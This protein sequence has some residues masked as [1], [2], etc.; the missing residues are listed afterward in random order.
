[1]HARDLGK[2]LWYARIALAIIGLLSSVYL[3]YSAAFDVQVACPTAGVI[4]CGAVLNS[5]YAKTFGIPNGYLGVLFFAAVLA[6][7]YL[8]RAEPLAVLNAIGIGFVI[9]FVH[10]E[11]VLGSICV[12]CTI[13]HICTAALLAISLYEIS[14]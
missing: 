8:K 4:N 13:V 2:R 9:Y 7:I 11:Y 12:Y 6:L 5:V 1:M 10:A 3:S 14:G